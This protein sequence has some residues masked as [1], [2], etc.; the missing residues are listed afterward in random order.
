MKKTVYTY[1]NGQLMFQAT[2]ENYKGWLEIVNE[3]Y[4]ASKGYKHV[5]KDQSNG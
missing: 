2:T 4:P 5:V 3:E 1:E